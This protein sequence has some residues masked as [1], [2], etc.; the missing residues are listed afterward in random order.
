MAEEFVSKDQHRADMAELRME[1]GNSLASLDKRTELIAQDL[2]ALRREMNDRFDRINERFDQMSQQITAFRDESR[3]E[4]NDLRQNSR[5]QRQQFQVFQT[6][7]QRQLWVLVTVV[8][9]AI[10][11][12]V[13]KLVFF[14]TP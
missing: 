3:R 11:T 9:A 14:P 1:L 5:D 13:V 8:A 7:T 2:M 6:N 4:S 10:V 12:G